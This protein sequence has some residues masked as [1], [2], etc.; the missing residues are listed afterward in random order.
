L[1]LQYIYK[2]IDYSQLNFIAFYNNSLGK[3]IVINFKGYEMFFNGELKREIEQKNQQIQTLHT[4]KEQLENRI[5]E[6]ESQLQSAYSE[7]QQLQSQIATIESSASQ[8]ANTQRVESS[9]S[10]Q[11]LEKLDGLFKYENENLKKGLLDI[12]SNLAESTELSRENLSA[13]YTINETYNH[14]SNKLS[15]IVSDIESLNKNATS[16]NQVVTQLNEKAT[17]IADAVVNIDQIAFQTNILSLNAAVEA[18]TAG[19]AGKGFAV[20]AQ[21]VRNLASRSA[22]SAKQITDVVKSIQESITQTNKEFDTMT[23]S[24]DEISTD[25]QTYSNDINS[26]MENSKNAFAGLSH[27]TDRVFMSLAK[28]DHVIWKVNTYLSVADKQPAFAFVDHRNCR[29][30]KWYNE[31]FGKR[32]FSNTPSYNKLDRPHSVVHNGT[33]KV[34]DTIEATKEN[35]D[36]DKLFIAFKEMEDAS[37][38]VFKL[39][40]QILHERD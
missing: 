38:D 8:T 32:Y 22:E 18:A 14:A 15:D 28:L 25:T 11:Q 23:H 2:W 7:K 21:E 29:L 3:M 12:Q 19:E 9:S 26:V 39:L 31:G 16:I 24:I 37:G 20:V 30:G 36:Y 4:S 27:I 33:H 40:D 13:S 34:F 10:E 17:D 5:K 6:L 1:Y 35:L